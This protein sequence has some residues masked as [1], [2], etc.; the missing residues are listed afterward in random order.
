MK[1]RVLVG[2]LAMVL[3]LLL[4]G[5]KCEHEWMAATCAA[6]KTCQKC[7]ETEGETL[8]HTW[9]EATCS[10]PKTCTVCG[11][12]EGEALPHTW[13]EATCSAPKTCTVCSATEGE[14]L[15]HTWQAASCTVA[16]TCE[17]CQVTEGDPLGHTWKN[18]DCTNPK[19]CT[20][21]NVT[22][23]D[24]L[25]HNW[26][27]ATTEA[28]KTCSR[29][30]HTDGEK[31]KTDSRFTTKDTKFLHGTWT[32]E[33]N[34][35]AEMM[36]LSSGFP[37]GIDCIMTMEFGNT[38]KLKYDMKHKD[39]A[40][41]MKSMKEYTVQATYEAFE[42]E[43]LNKT[44]ADQAMMEEIGLT[45]EGYVEAYLED[46]DPDSVF[47][48]SRLTEVYYVRDGK[49]YTAM[50]W[51]STIFEDS[52]YSLENGILKIDALCWDDENKPMEWVKQK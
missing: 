19:T 27:E 46:F 18:A 1:R 8:P 37:N 45:V 39:E 41:F 33:V 31:L 40:A 42:M 51:D 47:F 11:A 10:A 24:S 26:Q 32:S 12:T 34:M 38:G 4:T 9:Q 29:C 28:P 48:A 17:V 13:Q 6:P 3:I 21:C 23:G 2:I 30:A 5:C 22:E 43:G 36:G 49:I 25:G 35:T 16:K 44:Q 15:P 20:V 7:G 50:S 14:A 52:A